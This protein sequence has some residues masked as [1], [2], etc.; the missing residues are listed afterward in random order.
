MNKPVCQNCYWKAFKESHNAMMGYGRFDVLDY[1][2]QN[3]KEELKQIRE[4]LNE[5]LPK[6]KEIKHITKELW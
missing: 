6:K 4:L 3:V 5:L 1:E 2:L